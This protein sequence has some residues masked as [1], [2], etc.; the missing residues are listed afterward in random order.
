MPWISDPSRWAPQDTAQPGS[1]ELDVTSL[2][3][4]L[5]EPRRAWLTRKQPQLVLPRWLEA[6]QTRS[7]PALPPEPHP[8]SH[9]MPPWES[10]PEMASEGIR[11]KRGREEQSLLAQGPGQGGNSET[12]QIRGSSATLRLLHPFLSFSH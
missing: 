7:A 12:I 9:L 5:C 3:W 6:K 8:V 2:A 4:S 1:L 11:L 10:R